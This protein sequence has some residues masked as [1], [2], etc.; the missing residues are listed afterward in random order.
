LWLGC[1]TDPRA[2]DDAVAWVDGEP[3]T[4]A[5]L[6]VELARR[7]AAETRRFA[8]PDERRALL[9]SVIARRVLAQHARRAG[10]ESDPELRAQLEQLL[11]ERFERD[12]L[13]SRAQDLVVTAEAIETEYRQ[14]LDRYTAPE[15]VHA[16]LI[17]IPVPQTAT[18]DARQRARERAEQIWREARDPAASG[19]FGA[20]A[21]RYSSDFESRYRGGD[22][23]WLERG[24]TDPRW[25]SEVARAVF[26]LA[27]PGDVTEV[28]ATEAGFAIATLLR[29]SERRTAEL[30]EVE[31]QIR[32][33]LAV[34]RRERVLARMRAELAAASAV[35]RDERHLD[36]IPIF[37]PLET[38]RG[39][40][41]PG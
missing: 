19:G 17:W 23:G 21:L 29:R 32:E 7:G 25:G 16:A 38:A 39:G 14:N 37:P 10:Y 4:V 24:S 31:A 41:G 27:E 35:E 11:G 33:Q 22:I 36:E 34:Q 5:D 13:R 26:A 28:I 12:R 15:R 30:F 9:D 3:I 18:D 6:E 1:G 2:A 20:L 40:Q 8:T